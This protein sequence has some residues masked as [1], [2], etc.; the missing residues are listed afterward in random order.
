[1]ICDTCQGTGIDPDEK[2]TTGFRIPCS[3]CDG[4]GSVNMG[5]GEPGEDWQE[6]G[7]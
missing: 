7:V 1:M 3:T 2:F 5:N 6:N 4:T